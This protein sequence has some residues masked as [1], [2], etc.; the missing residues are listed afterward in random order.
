LQ[1]GIERE[2]PITSAL[3]QRLTEPTKT[4][5]RVPQPP[6]P[7]VLYTRHA[8]YTRP[9]Y[10]TPHLRTRGT[11]HT[12]SHDYHRHTARSRHNRKQSHTNAPPPYTH[13]SHI[14]GRRHRGINSST[15]KFKQR[16]EQCKNRPSGRPGSTHTFTHPQSTML[17]RLSPPLTFKNYFWVPTASRRSTS[18]LR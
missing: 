5:S 9:R 2:Q 6:P 17:K 4:W 10:I 11:P 18:R 13:T 8:A 14:A 3:R 1:L 16:L 12:R 7:R 15:L